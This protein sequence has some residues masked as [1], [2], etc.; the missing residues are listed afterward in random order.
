MDEQKRLLKA[1]EEITE[2]GNSAEVKKKIVPI[3]D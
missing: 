3:R 2:R 1:I